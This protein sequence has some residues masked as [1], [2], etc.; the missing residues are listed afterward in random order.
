MDEENATRKLKEE[1]KKIKKQ[2]KNERDAK[3]EKPI[4][5]EWECVYTVGGSGCATLGLGR[6]IGQRCMSGG[7]YYCTI[8]LLYT[9]DYRGTR[10]L[11]LSCSYNGLLVHIFCFSALQ[12]YRRKFS[13]H[14]EILT[15]IRTVSFFPCMLH[16]LLFSRYDVAGLSYAG[17]RGAD[18]LPNKP[19]DY[20]DLFQAVAS[21]SANSIVFRSWPV[22]TSYKSQH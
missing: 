16:V 8:S 13:T 1:K 15:I 11:P 3:R 22:D 18:I 10:Q 14:E 4:R 2:S 21:D 17:L 6:R 5:S 9:T 12:Y 19:K 7:I 20:S